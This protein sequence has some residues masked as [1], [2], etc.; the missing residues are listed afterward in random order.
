MA[1]S[2]IIPC[3]NNSNELN[4]TVAEVIGAL[5]PQ[6]QE[7]ILIDDASIDTT[8]QQ[9]V[10]LKSEFPNVIG[11]FRCTQNR[12]SYAALLIGFQ[13][14]QSELIAVMAADGDDPP[15]LLPQLLG[16]MRT[17]VD[18]VQAVRVGVRS[19][20]IQHVVSRLFYMT[21]KALGLKN[22][23]NGGS[24]FILVRKE[25]VNSM[26][27]HGWRK[28]N[29]LIQLFQLAENVVEVEYLKGNRGR[30][31]WSFNKKFKLLVY[32]L[33]WAVSRSDQPRITVPR[34]SETC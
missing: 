18:L 5:G 12:G 14:A 22:I 27:D 17:E 25:K 6:L 11:G 32:T 8:W 24:D 23:P 31:G 13:H 2:V 16:E 3:Y 21:L 15:A 4:S 30:S 34:V 20:V 28:G 29:T 7:I 10:G 26:Q 33:K 9:I 1:V 19:S